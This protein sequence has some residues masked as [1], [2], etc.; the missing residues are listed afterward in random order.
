MA[1]EGNVHTE[2][3]LI[4]KRGTIKAKI[5]SFVKFINEFDASNEV[6][7]HQ[8]RLRIAKMQR[9]FDSLEPIQDALELVATDELYEQRLTERCEIE[10][11]YLMHMAKAQHLLE[12][13]EQSRREEPRQSIANV[14]NITEVHAN[15]HIMQPSGSN[16]ARQISQS[17]LTTASEI[18]VKLPIMYLPKFSGSYEAWPDFAD[19]FR[20]AVHEN[21][22]FRDTQKLIY[23]RSCLTGKAAEKIESLETTAANYLVAWSILERYYNDPSIVIN[24][25]IKAIRGINKSLA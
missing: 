17:P 1:C 9:D 7:T 3:E 24:N 12:T 4:R 2:P 13:C 22:N 5:T 25:R 20:S 18:Q 11:S 15:E 21:P 16:N 19:A 6:G 14:Q 10:E 23:L 8:L